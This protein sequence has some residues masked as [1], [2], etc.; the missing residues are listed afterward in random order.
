VASRGLWR[1][2][3]SVPSAGALL[4]C[5]ALAGLDT[6]DSAPRG[7]PIDA[8]TR[9]TTASEGSV[10]VEDA[11]RG[12][13]RGGDAATDAIDAA[14]DVW[15]GYTVCPDA[16]ALPDVGY[17]RCPGSG[18]S[19]SDVLFR[20]RL[21]GSV[22]EWVIDHSSGCQHYYKGSIPGLRSATWD[23]NSEH[24]WI[25]R[26]GPP[27]CAIVKEFKAAANAQVIDIP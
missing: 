14:L 2:A 13:A 19:L 21:D 6:Y 16:F 15:T 17:S 11:P 18:E 27:T 9:D 3:W 24:T 1:G 4:S 12:D 8:T 20:N 7:E 5:A 23:T 22:E 26:A 10:V 25:M